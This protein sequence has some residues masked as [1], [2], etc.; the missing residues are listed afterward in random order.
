MTYYLGGAIARAGKVKG[1]TPIVPKTIKEEKEKVGRCK[2][3][4]KLENHNHQYKSGNKRLNQLD[5]NN[6]RSNNQLEENNNKQHFKDGE[7]N[8]VTGIERYLFR[9]EKKIHIKWKHLKFKPNV[10]SNTKKWH[11]LKRGIY[12]ERNG[13][14]FVT[15]N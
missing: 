14:D 12:Q 5:N 13:I 2:I 4:S 10:E 1:F 8:S 9:E 11:N 7:I 6:N 15:K 3:K